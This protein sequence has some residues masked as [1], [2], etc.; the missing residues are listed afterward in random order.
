MKI[1][2]VS[3]SH[4]RT[5]YLDKAIEKVGAIDL[6]I[7][8]G[9]FES[10]E[11]YIEAVAPCRLEMVSGNNDYFTSIPREKI[12][13]IGKYKALLTHGH[14]Y[15]V[16]FELDTIKEYGR[17]EG[18]DMVIFGHTHIPVI[19]RSGAITV[20]NPGS[21]TQ[22]RQEGRVPTFILMEIDDYGEAHY[23]INYMH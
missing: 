19:D 18:V 15:H 7:H 10:S 12:I 4:G 13:Q 1:L 23:T 6:M 9:D 17:Q 3:D 8:L 14:R 11:D 5:N 22:P 21:I 20:I 2:I 16:N